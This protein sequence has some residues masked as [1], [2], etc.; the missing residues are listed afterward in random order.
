ARD[1]VELIE[2]PF[3]HVRNKT[4]PDARVSSGMQW[5]TLDVPAVKVSDDRYLCGVGGPDGEVGPWRA[6]GTHEGCP[7]LFVEPVVGALIEVMQVVVA[8]QGHSGVACGSPGPCSLY[9]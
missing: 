6:T 2:S 9:H 5:M 1:N 7:E 3:T 4:F 8:K